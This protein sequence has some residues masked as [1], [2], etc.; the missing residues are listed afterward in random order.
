MLVVR[1][2]DRSAVDVL[3]IKVVERLVEVCCTGEVVVTLLVDNVLGARVGTPV[4]VTEGLRVGVTEGLRV[5][6]LV[7]ACLD[8]QKPN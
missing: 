8:M 4:G 3:K 2:V 5:G 1:E 6:G 7:G